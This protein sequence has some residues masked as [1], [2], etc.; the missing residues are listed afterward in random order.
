MSKPQR[1]LIASL[2]LISS[3]CLFSLAT[4]KEIALPLFLVGFACIIVAIILSARFR[5]TGTH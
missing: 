1:Y 5:A 4:L 3:G 2:A